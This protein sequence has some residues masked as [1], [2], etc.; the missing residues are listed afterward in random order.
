MSVELSR[1]SARAETG[2][3]ENKASARAPSWPF[4]PTIHL[5]KTQAHIS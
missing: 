1:G 2:D 3:A 4:P 5:Q